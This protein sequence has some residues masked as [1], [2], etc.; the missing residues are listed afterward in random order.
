MHLAVGVQFV[1]EALRFDARQH[2]LGRLQRGDLGLVVGV[3]AGV[4][5]QHA[6]IAAQAEAHFGEVG[7]AD[8]DHVRLDQDQLPVDAGL[9][10]EIHRQREAGIRLAQAVLDEVRRGE[11]IDGADQHVQPVAIGEKCIDQRLG[12][13]GKA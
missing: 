5:H 1:V 3:Q 8:Y 11:G 7:G 2:A 13:A 10:A 12:V 9:V 6:G 4:L